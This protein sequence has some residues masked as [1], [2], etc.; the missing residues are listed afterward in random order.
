MRKTWT[1]QPSVPVR[2]VLRMSNKLN[3]HQPQAPPTQTKQRKSKSPQSKGV[4]KKFRQGPAKLKTPP[5][6]SKT[7][8]QSIEEIHYINPQVPINAGSLMFGKSSLPP[9]PLD[10]PVEPRRTTFEK[11]SPEMHN[12]PVISVKTPPKSMREK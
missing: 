2:P 12:T 8:P 1:K 3:A 4:S 6:K 7:P 9:G 11:S 10:S 5:R